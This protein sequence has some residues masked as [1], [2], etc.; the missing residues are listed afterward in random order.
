MDGADP[1][2]LATGEAGAR[3]ASD[4]AELKRLAAASPGRYRVWVQVSG[5]GRRKTRS[6]KD[7]LDA[8]M[9][10]SAGTFSLKVWADN[11]LFDAAER[12]KAG[13]FLELEGDWETGTY[14]LEA[15]S[16]TAHP[17]APGEVD[18]LLAGDPARRERQVADFRYLEEVAGRLRDP[19]LRV[20]CALFLDKF[21]DRLRR[22]AGARS[23]HHAR[24]GG[25]VE[26]V[27]QMMRAAEAL[28]AVYPALN[29]DL[30]AAGV[31]FHDCGKLWENCYEEHGFGM[32]YTLVGELLSHIPVG[33]EVANHLW[34]EMLEDAER[35]G[36][37]KALVPASEEVRLHLLHLIGAHH[38]EHQF[39]SP[40][41]PKT[42][43]AVALHYIDNLDAKLEMFATGYMTSPEVAPGILE[44]VRPL[45]G[46]LVRQLPEVPG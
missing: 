46:H 45:P 24:R 5:V 27:A 23:F 17:L 40:V 20:L 36:A 41:L 21:G 38:G 6:D 34:H 39:G 14:G 35:A 44:R 37:W 4:S 15:K 8:A 42:P 30:L 9:A 1:E 28:C 13:D 43:E 31:I 16:W 32:P 2:L 11:P 29:R 25:L 18:A 10:D 12:W 3:R 19:R 7:F 26:H 22:S 33:I